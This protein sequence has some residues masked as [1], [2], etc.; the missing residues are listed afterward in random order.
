M[1][2]LLFCLFYISL[3]PMHLHLF[4][5]R[6]GLVINKDGIFFRVVLWRWI[7]TLTIENDRCRYGWGEITHAVKFLYMRIRKE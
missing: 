7:H 1:S 3:V 2:V 4:K 5:Y 6:I